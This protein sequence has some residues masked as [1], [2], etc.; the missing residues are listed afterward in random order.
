M[1]RAEVLA[2][3]GTVA[4]YTAVAYAEEAA[5]PR[6]KSFWATLFGGSDED[7]DVEEIRAASRPGRP[8]LAA[9]SAPPQ[10]Y[11]ASDSNSTV[12][13]ALQASASAPVTTRQAPVAL[14]RPEPVP[15]PVAA[16]PASIAPA[17]KEDLRPPSPPPLPPTRIAGLP[18]TVETPT[19]PTLNWQQGPAGQTPT[20]SELNMGREIA[21]APIPPRRPDMDEIVQTGAIAYAPLPPARPSVLAATNPIP[22]IPELRGA[23]N[24]VA[25]IQPASHPLPPPRPDLRPVAVAAAAPIALPATTGST[26][27]AEPR[28][29]KPKLPQPGAQ[30]KP[31]QAPKA[32]PVSALTAL[33]AAEPS[34]SMG[35]SSKPMGDLATNR[36]TGPAVKPLPVTQ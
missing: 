25:E 19:G 20:R 3:G 9:R 28:S 23:S 17:L 32:S 33:M 16:V 2:K 35:F 18:S 5:Q 1:A 22:G 34:L 14:A 7:E 24:L 15:Q 6:R 11:Y 26:A 36:F 10:N 4:G 13:A 21:L 31:P 8:V 27:R 29:E 12:Y 30:E